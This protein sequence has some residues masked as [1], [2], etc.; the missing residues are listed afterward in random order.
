MS[1]MLEKAA[2]DDFVGRFREIISDP[3]NLLIRRVPN[4]GVVEDGQVCLH[5]GLKV[6]FNGPGSY[7]GDF[8]QVL[9]INR[10]VHEPL[11]EYVFQQVTSALPTAPIM[12]EL[13]AYWGHYSMWLK[14][15]RPDATVYLV[16]PEAENIEAGK[17]NFLRN[18]MAG[19]FIQDF[20][21]RGHFQ[22][23]RFM[24]ERGVDHLDVLH[25]D[26]QGY[27]MEMLEACTDLLKQRKITYAFVSTHSQQLHDDVMRVFRS[28]GYRV[29]VAADFDEETTSYDGF[30]FASS[31]ETRAIGEFHPLSRTQI[32]ESSP[33][34][35]LRYLGR[36]LQG[37]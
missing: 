27:E 11:E 18:G 17:A 10:G 24:R 16:E 15:A 31:P 7:Y 13:G 19:E 28:F 1:K 37:A 23:D 14:Q 30:V 12:L 22:V 4:A 29:E 26:I 21:G 33:E 8:S 32:A 36:V 35:L 6:P 34:D 3:L 5:N 9:S 25:S 2:A 20:V